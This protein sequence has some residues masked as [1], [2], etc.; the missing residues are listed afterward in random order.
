[1]IFCGKKLNIEKEKAARENKE[2]NKKNK[3][4]LMNITPPCVIEGG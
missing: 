1:M 2:N 4:Q 3:E